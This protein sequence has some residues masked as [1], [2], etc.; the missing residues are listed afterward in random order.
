MTSQLTIVG[1]FYRE[2][3]RFPPYD[4]FWGSGGRAAAAIGELG[5]DT[6]FVTLIDSQAE[7]VLA[8]IAQATGFKYSAARIS[9]T[10]TFRYDH[11]LSTPIIWPPLHTISRVK[12]QASDDCILR[13]GMLEADVEA[14]ARTGIYDPQE[15]LSP[16]HF[17][18]GRKPSRL[19][20]VLNGSEA[21]KLGA[22][23]NIEE[24]AKR[25]A[26]DSGADVVVVK[27]G[28][29]GALV[30]E[31]GNFNTVPAFETSTVWPIGSGDVF[32]AVFAV[33]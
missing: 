8:S 13:F 30:L 25:I 27:R 10:I 4:E 3:C 26:L 17:Q 22:N 1:G 5:V 15:P 9:E 32:A 19:A 33:Q 12:L 6:R 2:K 28:P 21:R 18:S 14:E 16:R 20:Y 7:P 24:A 11:G 23:T 29:L 31:N